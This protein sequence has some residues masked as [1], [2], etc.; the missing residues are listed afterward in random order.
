MLLLA[1][2][3]DLILHTLNT[4]NS[5][6]VNWEGMLRCKTHLLLFSSQ[7]DKCIKLLYWVYS[8]DLDQ[9][10]WTC[11][12]M[13][14]LYL[15]LIFWLICLREQTIA[16]ATAQTTEIFHQSF[17]YPTTW[18]IWNIWTTN[19]LIFST[20]QAF[21]HFSLGCKVQFSKTCPKESFRF[22][23]EC[24]VNLLQGNLSE[25]KRSDMLNK[26]QRRNSRTVL[27]TNNLE[28]TKKSIFVTKRIVAYEN[29]F[30]LV[31]DHLSWDGTICSGTSFCLQQQQQPNYCH[32]T[33][34][35][36]IQTWANSHV[37]QRYVKKGN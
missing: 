30:P 32:K 26:V 22:L 23:S 27:K 34:I 9:L 16:Y 4:T 31:F 28:A 5:T 6:K 19:T 12:W 35:S 37:P 18:S 20:L 24:I 8:W 25:V 10:S 21:H 13:Q 36:Q 33:R 3:A 14:R 11:I 2:I 7:F 15:M 1:D 17:V 29:N